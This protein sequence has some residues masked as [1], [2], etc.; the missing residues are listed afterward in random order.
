MVLSLVAG[1]L[2][3]GFY[4]FV[5]RAMNGEG[6]PGPYATSFFFA[7]GVGVCLQL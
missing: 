1:L 5:S 7:L 4:P 6:A 2:T 3:G